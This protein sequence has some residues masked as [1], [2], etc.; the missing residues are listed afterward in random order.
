M[1]ISIVTVCYNAAHTVEKTIQSVLSQDYPDIEYIVIDGASTD[2][3]QAV[4]EPY[5]ARLHA[6]I[7][8]PDA[9][10]YD[11]MN[12]GIARAGGDIVGLLNADDVYADRG[13]IS[14]VAAAM[15]EGALDAV[16]GDVVFIDPQDP[17][18]V[19]RRY[20]SA[21]FSPARIAWGWMPA[22]PSL[23]LRRD[24]YVRYGLFKPAYRIAGDFEFIA[25][26]FK[27]GVLR[28]RYLP[29]V[30]VR[31][32]SGGASNGGW[33]KMLQLNREVMQACR[34]NGIYTHWL[35]LLSKYPIKYLETLRT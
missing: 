21:R 22:H 13:V 31:M 25:R 14:R 35:M 15:R 20:R 18:R 27:D 16:Y 24:I 11:A 8:E 34:E 3:T 33:R 26:I 28:S 7:S 6:F 5:R 29:E 2:G 12:K 4:V 9:G 10:I 23:F 17:G 32:R 19:V 1:K 30:L